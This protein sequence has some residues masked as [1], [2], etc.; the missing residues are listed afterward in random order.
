MTV[1]AS[2]WVSP[3]AQVDLYSRIIAYLKVLLPLTALGILATLFLL[4]RSEDPTATIPFAEA[5]IADRM[6]SQQVTAPSFLGTTS[7]GE[8]IVITA[9]LA[10]PGN[11]STPAEAVNL[12]GRITMVNGQEVTL[13]SDTGRFDIPADMATFTGN[14]RITTSTGL[15]VL[16]DVLNIALDRVYA[17]TPGTV[18]GSG[19]FGEFTAGQMEMSEKSP[20]GPVHMLFKN[21]V[22]LIYDP[23]QSER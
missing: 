7:K 10:R 17:D 1:F 6:R 8:E 23:K 22:K 12:S 18:D 9:S 2:V 20:G 5:D 3:G 14:V 19:P 11:A 4:S 13:K 21:G 16:S 15:L